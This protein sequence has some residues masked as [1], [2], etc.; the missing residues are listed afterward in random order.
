MRLRGRRL[1]TP[2]ELHKGSALT[3]PGRAKGPYRQRGPSSLTAAIAVIALAACLAL[4]QPGAAAPAAYDFTVTPAVPV[5]GQAAAFVASGLKPSD[6]VT[7]DFENDGV[8]DAAGSTVQH[9]YPSAGQRLVLMRVTKDDGTVRDVIEPVAVDPA[10]PGTQ[11]P[12]NSQPPGTQPPAAPPR[13]NLPPVA[14]FSAFPAQ[15]L[16]GQAV[17]FFSVS[18]DP[19]GPIVSHA[20][21]LDGDG[22]FD[23]AAGAAVARSFSSPG[24]HVVRLRVID[25][26][27]LAD[28]A[29]QTVLVFP[30]PT[31]APRPAELMSPFPV[32]RIVGRATGGGAVLRLFAVRNAPR[33]ATV[34][35]R[36]RGRG[37]P[38]RSR[39][40]S[41]PAGRAR[42]RPLE[43]RLRA[44]VL[45]RIFVTQ[46]GKIGKYTSFRI[47]RG[48]PPLRRDRCVAP[49]AAIPRRCPSS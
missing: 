38:L 13:A 45:I 26:G 37:C 12:P 25:S 8:F 40:R 23:D 14:S 16:A 11:P 6:T 32:I 21:D 17:Q 10:P 9:V 18:S 36:C 19:D 39:R 27:G 42:L 34:T 35:V 15:P 33:G 7:W 22:Q 2:H 5:A 47:R 43:R 4:T 46:P 41:M 24:A 3:A 44:G 30:Q 20:W 28:V 1:S 31:I 49:G 48:R 29:S